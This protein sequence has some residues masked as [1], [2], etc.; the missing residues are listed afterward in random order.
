MSIRRIFIIMVLVFTGVAWGVGDGSG[1]RVGDFLMAGGYLVWFVLLPLS[2][3]TIKQIVQAFLLVRR[4]RLIPGTV[5]AHAKESV[6]EARIKPLLEYLKEEGSFLS[7]VLYAGLREARNGRSAM[8]YSMVEML[9]QDTAE[10]LRKIEWLNII[11]N[12]APMIG[13]FGTVW[14]MI[15]AFNGIVRAGG[16]PEPAELAGGISVALVTTWWGLVVAIPALA[17]FGFLRNRIDS[18]SSEAAVTA[19]E[20]LS[21][22]ATPTTHVIQTRAGSN[23]QK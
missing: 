16:Q 9:E 22:V 17:A 12:V 19:E 2:V 15:D 20:L 4:S 3:L 23:I 13:L 1:G 7:R 8:E 11:G 18:I 14:G 6:A 21:S 10:L 5:A